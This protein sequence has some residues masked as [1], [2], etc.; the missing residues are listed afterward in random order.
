MQN[1][2]RP[3]A[4]LIGDGNSGKST[5]I[6][7]LA[8]YVASPSGPLK[9][10]QK[11]ME[12]VVCE[13][14]AGR[15]FSV[16]NRFGNEEELPISALLPTMERLDAD[17]EQ[18]V[19][20]SRPSSF[21]ERV[22]LIDLPGLRMTQTHDDVVRRFLEGP[23][24]D[25][26]LHVVSEIDAVDGVLD[27]VPDDAVLP[28]ERV[29]VFN[30]I[31]RVIQWE[32]DASCPESVAEAIE[33]RVRERLRKA[34]GRTDLV[35]EVVA[36][37]S[38]VSLAAEVWCDEILQGVLR[39]AESGDFA[40]LSAKH[41]LRT[42]SDALP[43]VKE[44]TAILDTA[45]RL[46]QGAWVVP[47]FHKPAF[48]AM[49]FGM[50]YCMQ[51]GLTSTDELRSAMRRCSGIER[52]RKVVLK[53]ATSP[54]IEKRRR[55]LGEV[56]KTESEM[57]ALR[58]SLG[59]TRLLAEK[60]KRMES[61]NSGNGLGQ[62]EERTFYTHLK[63]YLENQELQFSERLMRASEWISGVREAYLKTEAD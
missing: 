3:I 28:R 16:V 55:M 18:L 4:V 30:K 12:L 57:L 17:A 50:G 2:K 36:C 59:E 26:L 10:T 23:S 41:Y 39:L 60:A 37:S 35:P 51:R 1:E 49:R 54:R 44:R 14:K 27:E 62:N 38:L 58:Q 63:W 46:L 31:D 8:G 13:R 48:A 19:L 25:V 7:A 22:R 34:M 53:V 9:L 21:L 45:N 32:D 43:S 15:I 29:I 24:C 5:A 33:N 52:I 47:D 20:Y 40:V 61:K 11:P 56:K 42:E 6:S